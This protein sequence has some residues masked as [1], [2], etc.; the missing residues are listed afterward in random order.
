MLHVNGLIKRYG[1][2]LA[3]DEVDLR[4]EPGEIVGLLGP[5]GAGKTTL[6]SIVAGV[7][8][9]DEGSVT[10]EGREVGQ[11]PRR[12]R[13]GVGYAPQ[14]LGVYPTATV[15]ENLRFFGRLAGLRRRAT[16]A[17]LVDTAD[18][19]GLGPLLD[20]R[21]QVLSGGQKHRLHAAAA[22]VHRPRLALLDEPTVGA[23]V[24]TR[25]MLLQ[26]VRDLALD[27]TAVVYTTHYLQELEVLQAS[28]AVI[29]AGRV[30]AR[31]SQ[32]EL[33]ARFAS[34][35]VEITMEGQPPRSLL[36]RPNTTV[37]A[38]SG[39][40]Y[41]VRVATDDPSR[42]GAVLLQT[43]QAEGVEPRS[44]EIVRPGLEAAYL[45]LTGRRTVEPSA[46][47]AEGPEPDG[48]GPGLTDPVHSDPGRS[49][50]VHSDPGRSELRLRTPGAIE[51]HHLGSEVSDVAL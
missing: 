18:R 47:S 25:A 3:L 19:M 2:K 20:E 4:V 17:N 5:N 35:A 22:L 13:R 37:V 39:T 43:L 9:A 45:A 32:T 14:S 8:Q 6:V 36:D 23:D 49:D 28:L 38:V 16:E 50:P 27:G 42:S 29:E 33:V 7:R 34:S 10:I 1:A 26:T 12:V 11:D 51:P 40:S 31:G 46:G 30:I 44:I 48:R 15:R 41:T 24:E 21:V